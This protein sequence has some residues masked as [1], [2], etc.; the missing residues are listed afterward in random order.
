M[1]FFDEFNHIVPYSIRVNVG[2]N[3]QFKKDANKKSFLNHKGKLVAFYKKPKTLEELEEY[4]LREYMEYLPAEQVSMP[5]DIQVISDEKLAVVFEESSKYT[6]KKRTEHVIRLFNTDKSQVGYV[7]ITLTPSG[8]IDR[9]SSYYESPDRSEYIRHTINNKMIDGI[10]YKEESFEFKK[11]SEKGTK[12]VEIVQRNG[13][14]VGYSVLEQDLETKEDIIFQSIGQFSRDEETPKLRKYVSSCVVDEP[15][16]N[17]RGENSFPWECMTLEKDLF[18]YQKVM[19]RF[20]K[21]AKMFKEKTGVDLSIEKAIE[22]GY[23]SYDEQEKQGLLEAK[24]NVWN[25]SGLAIFLADESNNLLRDFKGTY[26][27]N[28]LKLTDKGYEACIVTKHQKDGQDYRLYTLI[29]LTGTSITEGTGLDK[30]MDISRDPMYFDRL[31]KADK[32]PTFITKIGKDGKEE[33]VLYKGNAISEECPEYDKFV[34]DYISPFSEI[35][36]IQI[37]K[38]LNKRSKED[39]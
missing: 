5:I 22:F 12:K 35:K 11:N 33:L 34:E 4:G 14:L 9:K 17:K 24:I 28:I 19:D 29:D 21:L 6:N 30:Y 36:P 16:F 18:K 15:D 3:K 32:T 13:E 7:C 26:I 23:L 25:Y 1:S 37:N 10:L 39:R 38:I 8:D 2:R 31:E 20:Q 27:G